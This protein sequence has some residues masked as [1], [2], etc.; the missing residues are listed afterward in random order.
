VG[1]VGDY[2]LHAGPLHAAH[3]NRLEEDRL[4][5]ND[6]ESS[7]CVVFVSHSFL[8][9]VRLV[10]LSEAKDLCIVPLQVHRS[11]ASLRMTK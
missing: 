10:I 2:C 9:E 3:P 5:K 4:E 1:I 6:A 11:F 8:P 7:A